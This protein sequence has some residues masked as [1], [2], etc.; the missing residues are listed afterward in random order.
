MS[1]YSHIAVI[2]GASSGIGEC[3]ARLLASKGINVCLGARSISK[4]ESIVEEIR[5]EGGSAYSFFLD[6]LD[7]RSIHDFIKKV[8]KIG[9]IK[10]LIN[11]SGFGKFDKFE[12]I[13]IKDW[14]DMMNVNLRSAFLMSKAFIPAMK[15]NKKNAIGYTIC[16]FGLFA[17]SI[18]NSVI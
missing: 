2:S 1:D 3:T 9:F 12:N 10:T 8:N 14:D 5:A 17:F 15:Q 6:F 4:L 7:D 13:S 16:L 11:N 18:L